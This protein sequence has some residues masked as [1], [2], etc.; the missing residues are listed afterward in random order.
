MARNRFLNIKRF[1]HFVDNENAKNCKDD[2]R[3]K[4]R[5]LA[6]AL[7]QK[8]KQFGISS[9]RLSIDEQ[10]VRYYGRNS[11]KQFISGKPIRFG[12]KQWVLCCATSGYCFEMDLLYIAK[13]T[14]SQ[15]QAQ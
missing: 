4:I 10:I 9:K 15:H 8:F 5:P 3:F 6:D 11:Q 13:K 12:F 2:K 1:L 7:N 14:F